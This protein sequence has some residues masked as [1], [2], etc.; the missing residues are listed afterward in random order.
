MKSAQFL[1]DLVDVVDDPIGRKMSSQMPANVASEVP[2]LTAEEQGGVVTLSPV[3]VDRHHRVHVVEEHTQ[4]FGGVGRDLDGR[5]VSLHS[6]W[7]VHAVV[8][9]V[10]V[11]GGVLGDHLGHFLQ[12]AT[13]VGHETQAQLP[14]SIVAPQNQNLVDLGVIQQFSEHV[15]DLPSRGG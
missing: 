9:G 1:G 5:N 13:V 2:M 15:N 3:S 10:A 6:P 11:L 12:P 7:L 4:S 8:A 14:R